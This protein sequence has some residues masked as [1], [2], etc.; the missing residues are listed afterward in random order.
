M[1]FGKGNRPLFLLFFLF[2]IIGEGNSVVGEG[3]IILG[4]APPASP[5]AE[6][7]T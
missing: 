5:P 7:Q 6:S 1:F 2:L 3:K 4:R